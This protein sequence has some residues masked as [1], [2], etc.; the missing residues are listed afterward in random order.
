LKRARQ[1]GATARAA[2]KK[3]QDTNQAAPAAEGLR[4]NRLN[5][6]PGPQS[7]NSQRGP[8]PMQE[9]KYS[10]LERRA[11]ESA[12]ALDAVKQLEARTRVR[13]VIDA[14][15]TEG[16]AMVLTDEEENMLRSFRRFKLRMRKDGDVFTWQTRRPDGFQ[17]GSGNR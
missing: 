1:H 6:A 16:T 5:G 7:N 11:A 8:E 9:M 15:K 3:R 17:V 4:F 13:D 12:G 10:E 14:M 2:P